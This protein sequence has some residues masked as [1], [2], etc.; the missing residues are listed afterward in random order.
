M[1]LTK[2]KALVVSTTFPLGADDRGTARFVYDLA[3]ALAERFDVWALA[4][5]HPGASR[6][7]RLGRVNVVRF[8]YFLPTFERVGDRRR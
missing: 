2:P 3:D 1:P 4:P 7:E 6:R 8:R 5:H